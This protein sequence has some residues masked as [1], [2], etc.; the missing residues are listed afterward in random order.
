MKVPLPLDWMFTVNFLPSLSF[1]L[2]NKGNRERRIVAD[3]TSLCP[4][5][6]PQSIVQDL[7]FN[8]IYPTNAFI[9]G[10][11]SQN[12]SLILSRKRTVP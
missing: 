9:L 3:A 7:I 11:L 8:L 12:S 1:Y 5:F 6:L 2:P 10:S 4:I